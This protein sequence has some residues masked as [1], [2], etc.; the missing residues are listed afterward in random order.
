MQA[1]ALLQAVSQMVDSLHKEFLTSEMTKQMAQSLSTGG[2]VGLE[3]TFD[4]KQG[5]ALISVVAVDREGSRLALLAVSV[6]PD[7]KQSVQIAH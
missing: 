7:T 6:V 5:P 4:D 2:R 3:M 1:E